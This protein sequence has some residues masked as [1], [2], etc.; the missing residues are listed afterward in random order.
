VPTYGTSE[1]YGQR[2]VA[3]AQR[4]GSPF[5]A[6][7]MMPGWQP[8][9]I[10]DWT[11]TPTPTPGPVIALS[12]AIAEPGDQVTFTATLFGGSI[13]VVGTQNDIAFDG[14]D[15]PIAAKAGGGPDCSVNPD[16]NTT[17]SFA[18][19]PLG[20]E[21]V[22]CTGVRAAVSSLEDTAPIP[23]GSILYTCKLNISPAARRNFYRLEASEVI[24]SGPS[25]DR[26]PGASVSGEIYI[27]FPPPPTPVE[28]GIRI[29]I[30]AVRGSPGEQV[31]LGVTLRTGG[32]DV[33]GVQNDI[34]FDPGS[35]P[36]AARASG[37]PDC[38]GNPD[39]SKEGTV[40]SFLPSGC[41]GVE[42]NTLRAIVVSFENLAPIPDG[43]VLYTC[44]IAIAADAATGTYPLIL[45]NIAVSSSTGQRFSD[46]SGENNVVAVG[47]IDDG[48]SPGPT[49]PSTATPA[50]VAPQPTA[51]A[52][53]TPRLAGAEEADATADDG[54]GCS[55]DRSAAKREHR[56]LP[57]SLVLFLP[58]AGLLGI[59][60]R[61]SGLRRLAP[62]LGG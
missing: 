21:G 28:P 34:I 62:S 17:A 58:A 46:V 4:L 25:G 11:F 19:L 16:I 59:R 6:W 29:V 24:L 18:F 39:I 53:G 49:V 20:C 40:F 15:T 13:I 50:G 9:L 2:I 56:G 60:R 5:I 42:C 45:S 48:H 41:S 55:I 1:D 38:S 3:Y 43:A 54:D 30:G 23:D 61:S 7:V 8:S 44:K 26:V 36:I 14:T 51:S 31:A 33:E 52:T 32:Q 57:R 47:G 12:S 35:A 22:A 27:R 10:Q 37:E